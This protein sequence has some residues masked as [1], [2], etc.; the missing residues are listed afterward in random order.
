MTRKLLALPLASLLFGACYTQLVHPD[1]SAGT[2]IG[3]V[4]AS[5]DCRACHEGTM[6][7]DDPELRWWATLDGPARWSGGSHGWTPGWERRSMSPWWRDAAH[8]ASATVAPPA[9]S[10]SA[11][12]PADQTWAGG[13]GDSSS[14]RGAPP[15]AAP[16]ASAA[17]DSGVAPPP[18]QPDPPPAPAPAPRRKP[19]R[20]DLR[21]EPAKP[22][23][24]KAKNKPPKSS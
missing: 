3:E 23:T 2:R 20:K 12:E 14:P 13:R 11:P 16:P 6:F 4:A 7:H 9:E 18:A 19:A 5:A 17:E 24:S 21:M 8:G 22:D 10:A 1:V 15:A